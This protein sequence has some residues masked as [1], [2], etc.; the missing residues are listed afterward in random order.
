MATDTSPVS[1]LDQRETT[2]VAHKPDTLLPESHYRLCFRRANNDWRVR[3]ERKPWTDPDALVFV[4]KY[5]GDLNGN[6]MDGG[7]HLFHD[8]EIYIDADEVA[9]LIDLEL[10]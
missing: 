2:G 9:H 3:D 5:V 8:G 1:A 10:E 7:S 6:W 4:R